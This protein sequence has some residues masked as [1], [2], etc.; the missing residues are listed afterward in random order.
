MLTTVLDK[1]HG[2][3]KT[4]CL[5]LAWQLQPNEMSNERWHDERTAYQRL[6]H[7]R[8]FQF[9]PLYL[10]HD[11]NIAHFPFNDLMPPSA[12]K[13][14]L[15]PQQWHI[16]CLLQ[17]GNETPLNIAQLFHPFQSLQLVGNKWKQARMPTRQTG[18]NQLSDT[19]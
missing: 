15:K 3:W 4:V 9:L 11:G 10:S 1:N 5:R 18:F 12:G 8:R 16:M 2:E 17:I 14:C 19:L 13:I 7:F 6:S